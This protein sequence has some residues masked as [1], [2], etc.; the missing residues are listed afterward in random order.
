MRF[1]FYNIT[2]LALLC[3]YFDFNS[4]LSQSED[5]LA[6]PPPLPRRARRLVH[7]L[8]VTERCLAEGGTHCIHSFLFSQTHF[9]LMH[10]VMQCIT[11]SGSYSLA[12]IPRMV[13]AIIG[14]CYLSNFANPIQIPGD[15]ATGTGFIVFRLSMTILTH[16]WSHCPIT[17]ATPCTIG[18]EMTQIGLN[19]GCRSAEISRWQDLSVNTAPAKCMAVWAD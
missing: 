13:T 16:S 3:M 8:L 17:I 9:W 10:Y 4:L 18:T 6:S 14:Q 2:C 5:L 1:T 7:V 15:I 12:I 11:L 19:R